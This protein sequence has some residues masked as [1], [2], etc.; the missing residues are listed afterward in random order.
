MQTDDCYYMADG[1][2]PAA[3]QLPREPRPSA[4]FFVQINGQCVGKVVVPL[5][6]YGLTAEARRALETGEGL[7]PVARLALRLPNGQEWLFPHAVG[8][9]RPR[10]VLPAQMPACCDDLTIT[11]PAD[12]REDGHHRTCTGK[13][14]T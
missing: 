11:G 5:D 9:A 13:E 7:P 1:P 3:P 10:F 12:V 4:E 14:P 8:E 6:L 2:D